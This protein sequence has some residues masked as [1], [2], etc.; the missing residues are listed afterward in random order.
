[1]VLGLVAIDPAFAPA[2]VH[3][4]GAAPEV[5]AEELTPR[6]LQVLQLL[7]E[8]LPNKRVAL[9]LGISEH[10]VKFHVAVIFSKLGAHGR[11]EAVT[12]AARLGLI[13]L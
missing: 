2:L 8:G 6:E 5:P 9:Q 11:T 7:A 13:V 1:M 10:T 3:G 4:R 12:R